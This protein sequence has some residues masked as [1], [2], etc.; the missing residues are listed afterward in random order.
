ML[1]L[2]SKS[3]KFYRLCKA[4]IVS[5]GLLNFQRGCYLLLLYETLAGEGGGGGH[6][7][8]FDGNRLT[9]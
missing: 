3:T 6:L 8:Q 5:V 2:Y 7:S 9:G 4:C 1:G